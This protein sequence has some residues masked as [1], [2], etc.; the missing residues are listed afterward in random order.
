MQEAIQA[1]A[2]VQEESAEDLLDLLST[3]TFNRRKMLDESKTLE[4]RLLAE[5]QSVS[6]E[7]ILST[8]EEIEQAAMRVQ[9]SNEEIQARTLLILHAHVMPTDGPDELLRKVLDI[10][11]DPA[12]ADEALEFLIRTA[13]PETKQALQEARLQFRVTREREIIA[14]RNMGAQA[15]EFSKEGLGSP[16]FLRDLYRDLTGN[17]REPLQ[18]FLE[19]SQGFAYGKLKP[20]IS[21]L[22]HA[23]GQELKSQGPSVAPGTLMRLME[24]IRSLQGI[25]GVY[26]F[27][28]SRMRILRQQFKEYGAT[29]PMQLTFEEI[30]KGF[31]KLLAER[32]ISQEK[33]LQ[34]A[35]QFGIDAQTIAQI[36]VFTQMREALRQIAPRYYR[37]PKHREE[38][39]DAFMETIEE[40][41]AQDEEE[42]GEE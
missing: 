28:Q 24:E 36:L 17:P 6:E 13:S 41:E 37:N 4:D 12:L 16:T 15:R 21:F 2:C 20:I 3:M 30:S 38:L 40:L 1:Q 32:Y 5:T 29:L 9:R 33:I 39:F 23:M 22:L 7:G 25:L 11:S 8:P 42:E 35:R 34:L 14:G 18:L 10:Y 26:R 19:L 31:V 27:F